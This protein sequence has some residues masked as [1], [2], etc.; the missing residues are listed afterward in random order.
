MQNE[1]LRDLMEDPARI[2]EMYQALNH[3]LIILLERFSRAL[4]RLFTLAE[5]GADAQGCIGY[6]GDF[7]FLTNDQL[8]ARIY[9]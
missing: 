9:G 1:Q 5:L 8:G 6:I 2:N 4:S 7:L 3:Q